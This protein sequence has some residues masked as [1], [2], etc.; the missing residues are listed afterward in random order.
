MHN[1]NV[2]Q[3]FTVTVRRS[4]ED[5]SSDNND[6]DVAK[7]YEN[8]IKENKDAAE[9]LLPVKKKKNC[10]KKAEDKKEEVRYAGRKAFHK[11]QLRSSTK[12]Q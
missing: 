4:Y 8:F 11:Y 9:M 7:R 6:F 12:N 2:Q 1:D 10:V 5:L 3:L